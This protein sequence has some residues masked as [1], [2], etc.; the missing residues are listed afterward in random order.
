MT[1]S[2]KRW[3]LVAGLALTLVLVWLAPED[4]TV[5]SKPGAKARGARG[6]QVTSP[7]AASR[8]SE[9]A[10]ALSVQERESA[11][12]VAD[13]FSAKSWFVP[14]PPPPPPPPAPVL[15]PPPPPAPTAPP[16]P[17]TFLGQMVEDQR[18][19]VFLARGDRVLT[20]FVG[21]S[22]D[23]SYRLESLRAGVLTFVY[24]P[25]DIKQT[26]ATG[27]SQ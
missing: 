18:A 19:Q 5:V 14:P 10:A 21:A 4:T 13:L 17:F 22:I 7:M 16:L 15:P 3:L 6:P 11:S 12:E 20:V 2:T 8:Q 27:V 9:R 23:A 1:P 25:L 24:V 26:L